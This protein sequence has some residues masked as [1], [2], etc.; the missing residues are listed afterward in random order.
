MNTNDLFGENVSIDFIDM[1]DFHRKH[2]ENGY[3]IYSRDQWNMNTC[4]C[5]YI[6]GKYK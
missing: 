5:I 2:T 1:E 6:Y 4:V 3:S